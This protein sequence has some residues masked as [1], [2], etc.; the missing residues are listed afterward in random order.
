MESFDIFISYSRRHE[1]TV[2]KIKALLG[3][4]HRRVFL[5]VDDV[6]PGDP[7]S[8]RLEEAVR[9]SE[10]LV[11]LW[12]CDVAKSKWAKKEYQTAL[13]LGKRV[14][15]ILLC[16]YELPETLR[17]Y[18]WIDFSGVCVHPCRHW[19]PAA[20]AGLRRARRDAAESAVN[21][22][23]NLA[24]DSERNVQT[25]SLILRVLASA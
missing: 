10:L 15:P 9:A 3:L 22:Y 24:L 21:H 20:T 17:A 16:R 1:D 7:W 19:S 5:D 4:N 8:L 12:C 14:V 23:Q 11:L 2:G 6:E 18:Q 13:R 25:L